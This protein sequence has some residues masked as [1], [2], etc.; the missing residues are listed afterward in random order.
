MLRVCEVVCKLCVLARR[1]L[2]MIC[3]LSLCRRM[4]D[5]T[6]C[7]LSSASIEGVKVPLRVLIPTSKSSGKTMV[8]TK[9]SMLCSFVKPPC[10]DLKSALCLRLAMTLWSS[11]ISFPLLS[12]I[13]SKSLIFSANAL[14][15]SVCKA[16]LTSGTA[17]FEPCLP[18]ATSEGRIPSA[19]AFAFKKLKSAAVSSNNASPHFEHNKSLSKGLSNADKPSVLAIVAAFAAF[20]AAMA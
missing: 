5:L 17:I 4:V 1:G 20:A 18:M 16:W 15:C 14:S 12:S 13:S 19:L 3:P 6:A 9:L 2:N 11:L 8:V 10:S 7:S